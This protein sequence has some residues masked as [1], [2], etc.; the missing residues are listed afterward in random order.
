MHRMNYELKGKELVRGLRNGWGRG[1]SPS[2]TGLER[3][4][5]NEGEGAASADGRHEK[6]FLR[7]VAFLAALLHVVQAV[8]FHPLLAAPRTLP[9]VRARILPRGIA[10]V[11]Q[12]ADNLLAE[13]LPRLVI[14]DVQHFL[15]NDQGV[16]FISRIRLSR[17]RRAVFHNISTSA[18]NK[19]S[20]TMQDLD[21][22]LIG[23]LSG[24]VN[25]VVPFNLTGQVEILANG[26]TF[27]LENSILKGEHGAG[28]T[29]SLACT[30]TIREV[31]VTNHN[32]GLFGLAVSVFKQGVSDNVR[33]LLQGLICKK[34]RKYIDEDLNEK[35]A[36]AQTTSRLADAIE[37]N[38]LR[39]VNFPSD[40]S[41]IQ[42]TE[43]FPPEI[44]TDFFI[45]FRLKEHPQCGD[46][47]VELASWGEISYL[48]SSN[49]PF[50]PVDSSW[51]GK[52][53]SS[54][55]RFTKAFSQSQQEPMIELIISD[56]LPNSFL[57][58]AYMNRLI[59]VLLTN[60]T[61]GISSFLHT[62]CEGS[63]CIAD[64]APQLAEHFPNSTV[65]LSL[66]ATRAPALLFSEKDSGVISVSAGAMIVVFAVTGSQK[67]Q[68]IVMDMDIV[69]DARLSLQGQNV[70]GTVVLRKFELKRKA[71]P[72]Q[73]SNA[74]VDDI[75]LLVGKVLEEM[76]NSLLKNGLPLPLPHVLR[77]RDAQ[78]SVLSRRLHLKLDVEV[79]ERRLSRIAA[80]TFFKTPQFSQSPH[81]FHH[82]VRR[83]LRP[84]T[85]PARLALVL[86]PFCKK[87]EMSNRKRGVTPGR[88]RERDGRV[89]RKKASD[90]DSI[91]VVCRICPFR[92]PNACLEVVNDFCVRT[93]VP[94]NSYRREGASTVDKCFS[95]G[96]V[97]SEEDGQSKVFERTAVDLINNLVAGKNS[98]LFTYGVT[99]SGKTYTMTGKPTP[100]ETGL[101]PR[102]LD[103]IFNSIMNKVEKCVF[104]QAG[105]NK[106]E[107]RPSLDAL[108]KRR[109]L[110]NERMQTSQEM[111]DRYV[112]RLTVSGFNEDYVCSV[113]VSY[114]EIYN[115]YCYDLLED[116]RNSALTKREL[117]H[118]RNQQ[119]FVDGAR[120]MEVDSSDEAL[121]AFCKGEERRRVSSTLLNKDSSRSH[122]V[123]TIKLVMAPREY[124]SKSPMPVDDSEAIVVSQ[125]CLVD[126]AGSER[127]KRTMNVG[128]RLQEASSINQSLMVLRQC[129]DVLRRNQRSR[130]SPDQVPYR[131]SKLTHL[132]K[133]YLEGNGKIRMVICVNPRPED[134]DENLSAL[135]F[136]EES[137][138]VNVKKQVD[139][140][141][142]DR[143]PHRFHSQWNSEMDEFLKQL[144]NERSSTPIL[145]SFVLHDYNDTRTISNL[146]S[147]FESIMANQS[148]FNLTLV[149]NYMMN[150]DFK[151]EQ[152]EKI[153]KE[154]EEKDEEILELK[155][156][157]SKNKREI[158]SLRERV[159]NCEAD[160][161]ENKAAMERLRE[162]KLEDR[163]I[164]LNQKK[165]IKKVQ[166]IIENSSPSVASLRTKFDK[167]NFS[168]GT[169][170]STKKVTTKVTETRFASSSSSNDLLE[171]VGIASSNGPG[172][173]NP[174]YQRRSKSASRV[175]DH[176]PMHRV[177]TGGILRSRM[178][179]NSTRVTRPELRQLNKSSE[180]VLTHQEVDDDG[181]IST[182]I[183]KGDCI[184]TA[185]G[186]TAVVFNDIEKLSHESP[187]VRR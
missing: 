72:I 181:N 147:F 5:R 32:G 121:E 74:E 123:F 48:G 185:G 114:V 108:L 155:A 11:N 14:P 124:S 142:C 46:N 80:R 56:F 18:P 116:T 107:I 184:P 7:A 37:A 100:N 106:F 61:S 15:P 122:S 60:E 69:A 131:Q 78:V 103:V 138:A 16:I 159:V 85:L 35:L 31:V 117:R 102:T 30:T 3:R 59:R 177:P 175:L 118:D 55:E 13:Q 71:G 162:E 24:S 88:D 166:G 12:I 68:A 51:P 99:G 22:G 152:F 140:M 110:E 113:F 65:E 105:M 19:I 96:C 8:D 10:Y 91:E 45:D 174:K 26:I 127:A 154:R 33:Q 58:H 1:K 176:Q 75:A 115:N 6:M 47:T 141:N 120:E 39:M 167:E 92:G 66:T 4:P 83:A 158:A 73:I 111:A 43:F 76:F 183:I 87:L 98:L 63:F 41:R 112:E 186:G 52:S 67:R 20:W 149:R 168:P 178:P 169:R 153:C 2:G 25:I 21:L 126:L 148:N 128:D 145:P 64:V 150:A 42:L 17:F 164:I 28:K 9:G 84:V 79:D 132:F 93:V 139:R 77:I 136:A 104:S 125:L 54:F 151:A 89:R 179:P 157:L 27:H 94:P 182:N 135:S 165:A 40:D 82:N 62:T 97:F 133:N 171:N 53:A 161:E 144:G 36:E 81:I 57:Y 44:T 187:A 119:I 143:V 146:R 86:S 172:Y 50:G 109:Q 156:K 49:T 134:Y 180:Y 170:V 101:L 137:Q 160:E 130:V 129:I 29:T 70:S 34:V 23:D 173:F 38:A 95:F 90:M 163:N